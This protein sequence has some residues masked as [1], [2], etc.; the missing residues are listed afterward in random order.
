VDV[1][2]SGLHTVFGPVPSRRFGRSLGVDVIP[3]K[4]CSMDCVYC[5][6]G[7]T[8]MRDII[9]KEYIP[10]SWIL[11]ELALRL[12]LRPPIEVA[13]VERFPEPDDMRAQQPPAR[14]AEGEHRDRHGPVLLNLPALRAS[15]LPDVAVNF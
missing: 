9:R 7:R 6:V 8:T 13:W 4:L 14:G 5:E 11:R 10:T 1:N 3:K 12:A 2:A 15:D